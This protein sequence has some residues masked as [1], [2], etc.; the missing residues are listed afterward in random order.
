MEGFVVHRWTDRWEEGLKQLLEWIKEGK[1][2]IEET[3][4]N[5]FENMPQAFIDMLAGK[6]TGKAVV[7][8]N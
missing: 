3:F 4:T 5:G 2:K 7:K 1:I 6:N 8:I